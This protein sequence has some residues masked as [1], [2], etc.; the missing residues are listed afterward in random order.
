MSTVDS[1]YDRLLLP[2]TLSTV[3]SSISL[4]N[5]INAIGSEEAMPIVA[6]IGIAL[7]VLLFIAVLITVTTIVF[8]RKQMAYDVNSI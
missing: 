8:M 1:N 4:Q 7:G 2:T 5:N 6:W 3:E